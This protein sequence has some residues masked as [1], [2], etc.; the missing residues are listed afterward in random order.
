M[1]YSASIELTKNKSNFFEFTLLAATDVTVR[2]TNATYQINATLGGVTQTGSLDVDMTISLASGTYL[3]EIENT[4]SSDPVSYDIEI[5]INN[6][7]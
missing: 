2:S 6:F 3:L 1:P 7:K 4:N 5:F